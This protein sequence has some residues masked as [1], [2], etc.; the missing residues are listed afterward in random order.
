MTTCAGLPPFLDGVESSEAYRT[1]VNEELAA[2]GT[3][4]VWNGDKPGGTVNVPDTS[5][6]GKCELT[7]PDHQWKKYVA[8]AG[9]G[10]GALSLLNAD[11]CVARLR[12]ETTRREI[13]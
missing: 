8:I 7:V 4:V 12:V 5:A 3:L 1:H 10:P 2:R 6:S 11:L 13:A 9:N